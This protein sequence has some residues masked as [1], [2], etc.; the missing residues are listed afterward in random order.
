[1]PNLEAIGVDRQDI[2]DLQ[3]SADAIRAGGG[4][5][6]AARVD[7][8]F[9]RLLRQVEQ[10]ELMIADSNRSDTVDSEAL[11][12]QGPVSDAAADYYRRLSEQPQRLQR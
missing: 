3:Q 1:M 12:K 2:E 11:V 10:L 5:T 9:Q 7:A 6:N 4:S 8:E